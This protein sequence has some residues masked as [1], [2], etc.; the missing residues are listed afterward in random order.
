MKLSLYDHVEVTFRAYQLM[1]TQF[2]LQ[3]EGKE[4]N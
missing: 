4:E 1:R 3:R 2:D